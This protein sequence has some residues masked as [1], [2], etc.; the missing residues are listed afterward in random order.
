MQHVCISGCV[1]RAQGTLHCIL[2]IPLLSAAML[3]T[4][5][6]QDT[7]TELY[8]VVLELTTLWIPSVDHCV[9]VKVGLLTPTVG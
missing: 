6:S 9:L 4:A 8:T 7:G 5:V 3:T 2:C 1:F